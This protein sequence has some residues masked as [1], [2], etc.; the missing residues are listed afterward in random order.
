MITMILMLENKM[1]MIIN[2]KNILFI[3]KML[4][5]LKN[6]IRII[7]LMKNQLKRKSKKYPTY[8]CCHR[9]IMAQ[10]YIE[11]NRWRQDV[12]SEA[13][14]LNK[15]FKKQ[16]KNF[17]V[18]AFSIYVLRKIEKVL[19]GACFLIK[20]FEKIFKVHLKRCV[21][22]SC[23]ISLSIFSKILKLLCKFLWALSYAFKKLN[24]IFFT[25]FY[26]T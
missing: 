13:Q 16:I 23:L 14:H 10:N 5:I 17:K 3:M 7:T 4:L 6:M 8:E 21:L 11:I 20:E 25:S 19:Q 26:N 18:I 12:N 22:K 1:I 2:L 9:A 15:I 24:N